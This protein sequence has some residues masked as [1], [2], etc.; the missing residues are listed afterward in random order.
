[1]IK[2][3]LFSVLTLSLLSFAMHKY[4][5]SITEAEYNVE[6]KSFEI[7]I[8]FIGH[9]L[10][11]ALTNAGAPNLYLGTEK[12]KS[13]ADAYLKRYID[14]KFEM[15]VDGKKLEYEFVGKEINND[16]FIYCFIK[17]N[18]IEAPKKVFIK[19][20]MLT[21]VFSGQANTVY[22]KSGNQKASFYLTKDKMSETHTLS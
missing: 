10:E 9:D 2:K 3:I 5:V 17:S 15:V 19:S 12:E 11:K 1:M 8:K 21:E 4:Y 13:N 7:S 18:K 14:K 16:D 20:S 6:S 22:L